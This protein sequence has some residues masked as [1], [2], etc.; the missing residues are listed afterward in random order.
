MEILNWKI[1]KEVYVKLNFLGAFWGK[2]EDNWY[3]IQN[4]GL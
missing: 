3:K 2:Y 4:K 1:Y